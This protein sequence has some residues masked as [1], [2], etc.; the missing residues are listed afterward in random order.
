M[1]YKGLTR[2]YALLRTMADK[3]SLN[4]ATRRLLHDAAE[5]EKKE[6]CTLV[7]VSAQPLQHDLFI[8]HANIKGPQGTVY[9]GGIFHFQLIIP[10]SYPHQPPTIQLMTPLPHP[11]V[12]GQRICLDLLQPTRGK[13][14]EGWSSAYSI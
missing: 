7:G 12:F 8:W 1:Q 4:F 6:N 2:D 11:N 5:L 13:T 9:E 10:E 14:G 3:K